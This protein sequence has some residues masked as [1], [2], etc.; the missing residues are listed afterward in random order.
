MSRDN[1]KS[2]EMQSLLPLLGTLSAKGE[3]KEKKINGSVFYWFMCAL[4]MTLTAEMATNISYISISKQGL[5]DCFEEIGV[6]A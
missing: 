1:S 4:F 2:K 5:M 6:P 3:K